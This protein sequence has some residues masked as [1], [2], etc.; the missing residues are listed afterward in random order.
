MIFNMKK[1]LLALLLSLNILFSVGL[2]FSGVFNNKNNEDEVA[3]KKYKKS[4]DEGLSPLGII[5]IVAVSGIT[6]TGAYV[7]LTKGRNNKK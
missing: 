5:V 7:A 3:L 6:I 2:G 1:K 4:E